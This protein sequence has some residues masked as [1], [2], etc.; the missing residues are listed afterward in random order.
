MKNNTNQRTRVFDIRI[1]VKYT[2][3]NNKSL[4]LVIKVQADKFICYL[5]I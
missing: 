5:Q 4:N 1:S 3:I 2:M